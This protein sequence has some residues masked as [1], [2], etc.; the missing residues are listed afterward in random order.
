MTAMKD[1][2]TGDHVSESWF[3][4]TPGMSRIAARER[5]DMAAKYIARAVALGS[6]PLPELVEAFV[7]FDNY[8]YPPG[9]MDPRP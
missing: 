8:M 3:V 4:L 7:R 9:D 5:R 2:A 1:R 6:T